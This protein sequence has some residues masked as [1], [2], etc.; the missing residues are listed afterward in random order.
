MHLCRCVVVIGC[1]PARLF[2]FIMY[3]V[4]SSL[5]RHCP[6]ASKVGQS[7]DQ[8]I[9]NKIALRIRQSNSKMDGEEDDDPFD[10]FGGADDSNDE[11]TAAVAAVAA[12]ADGQQAAAKSLVEAANARLAGKGT[13]ADCHD[14]ELTFDVDASTT[15]M[16]PENAF[17]PMRGGHWMR[18]CAPVR[19]YHV[20]GYELAFTSLPFGKQSWAKYRSVNQK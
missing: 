12:A 14:A 7:T 15:I 3:W 16:M 20:L 19:F 11:G 5:S 10:V 13:A 8:S 17:M 4:M 2:G 6:S 1:A 18:A 9:K